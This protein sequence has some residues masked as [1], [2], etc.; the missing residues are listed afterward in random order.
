MAR[1]LGQ[2]GFGGFTPA[3]SVLFV[4]AVAYL[5]G[6]AVAL[7]YLTWMLARRNLHPPIRL[8][9]PTA[10]WLLITAIPLG[11]A[12]V[13]G[14]ALARIDAVILSLIADNAA[15]GLYGAAYR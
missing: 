1:S 2:P 5:A 7:A 4:V 13:L 11:I 14:V 3:A 12:G 15:V 9:L 6:S 10:R 8:S